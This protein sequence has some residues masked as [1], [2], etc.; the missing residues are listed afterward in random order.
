MSAA[1]RMPSLGAGLVAAL[2]LS[3]CGAALLGA[4]APWLGPGVALRAVIALLGFAY[5][6]YAIG[7]SGERV[8]RITTLVCWI[9]VASGAWLA[10]LPLVAYVLVALAPSG[11]SLALLL[12]GAHAGARRLGATLLGAAF[13]V[14]PRS[15][16]SACLRSGASSSCR[17][18]TS[19]SPLH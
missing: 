18:S 6:I 15:A 5:V 8:G 17:R 7:R 9:V 19:R 16:D 4:L 10:G 1:K 12:L 2:I 14:W 3:A 13:A 11:R